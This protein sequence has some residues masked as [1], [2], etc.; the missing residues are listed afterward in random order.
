MSAP[1]SRLE[2]IFPALNRDEVRRTVGPIAKALADVV[3]PGHGDS[4][5]WRTSV[6]A[7]A[8]LAGEAFGCPGMETYRFDVS[9]GGVSAFAFDD[10]LGTLGDLEGV[11]GMDWDTDGR[12]AEMLSRFGGDARWLSAAAVIV[13][14]GKRMRRDAGGVS[15]N[16][17]LEEAHYCCWEFARRYL[18]RVYGELEPF[19]VGRALQ[20]VPRA[21]ASRS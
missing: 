6:R 12:F 21:Q 17:V 7:A 9:Q 4:P 3:S 18:S 14:V 15:R 5:Q 8:C 11:G 13:L 20:P 1:E 16:D 2:E 10:A 19:L